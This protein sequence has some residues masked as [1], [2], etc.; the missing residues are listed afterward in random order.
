[1]WVPF[2][3]FPRSPLFPPTGDGLSESFC[4]D[5]IHRVFAISRNRLECTSD[6]GLEFPYSYHEP[7]GPG[8]RLP[9]SHFSWLKNAV[10]P[11]ICTLHIHYFIYFQLFCLVRPQI[12]R[13]YVIQ[14]SDTAYPRLKSS[15]NTGELERWYTPNLEERA[16]CAK[17]VRGQSSRFGFLLMLKTFQR[18]GYFVT[19]DHFQSGRTELSP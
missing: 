17:V 10:L 12:P 8:V 19:S 6:G 2:V 7:T 11:S 18:L 14:A 15:F 9:I 16:Y 1:M 4:T 5:R 13:V 3:G